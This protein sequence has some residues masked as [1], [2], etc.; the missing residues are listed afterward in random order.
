MIY[1]ICGV[2]GAGKTWV[3]EQLTNFNYLPHDQYTVSEYGKALLNAEAHSDTPILAEA[4]FRISL[5]IDE[6]RQHGAQVKTY[7][8]NEPLHTIAGRYQVRENKA[9]PKQHMTNYRKYSGREW[10][11]SGSSEDVL[12]ELK[13]V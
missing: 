12:Q 11:F 1:L 10:T 8:I 13:K 9:Y 2:P 7:Y 3:A 5:L 4:P 6:L